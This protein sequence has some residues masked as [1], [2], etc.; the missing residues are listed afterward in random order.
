MDRMS[1]MEQLRLVGADVARMKSTFG[2]SEVEKHVFD[3]LSDEVFQEDIAKWLTAWKPLD[4]NEF[5]NRWCAITELP[6]RREK[7]TKELIRDIH[8]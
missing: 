8:S 7:S 3:L 6:E 2:V 5:A 1:L 4:K